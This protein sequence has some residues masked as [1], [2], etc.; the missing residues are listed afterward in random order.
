MLMLMHLLNGH[1]A[2]AADPTQKLS[3]PAAAEGQVG[4]MQCTSGSISIV[5]AQYGV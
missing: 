4:K 1:T 2:N 5:T 3:I